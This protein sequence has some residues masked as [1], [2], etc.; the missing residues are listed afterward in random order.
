Y[1]KS[2]RIFYTGE[3]LI[4]DFNLCDYAIGFSYLEFGDRYLRYPNFAFF[5]DQFQELLLL[6]SINLEDLRKK[7]YFC[8]FIYSNSQADPARDQFFHLLSEYK[9]VASPGSH[10]NNLVM[11]VGG[12]YTED[13]MYTKLAFQSNCKFSIAFENSSSPGYTTEKLMHA[14]ITKTIPIYWGNPEVAKDFNPYSLI[15]C[16]EFNSFEEVVKRVKEIDQNDELALTYLNEPP[17]SG[18][19]VPQNLKKQKLEMFLRSIFD[20]DLSQASRRPDYGTTKKYEQEILK[21]QSGRK[22]N[23]IKLLQY[24]FKFIKYR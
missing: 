10:L 13:W 22:Y 11:D 7:E 5:E 17:F 23:L 16:H 6:R 9:R 15:N 2:V 24:P 12:R 3:N 4:P 14:Y 20:Q 19:Q 1:K 8:N 21:G 18:N